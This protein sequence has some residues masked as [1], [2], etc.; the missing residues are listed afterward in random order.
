[1]SAKQDPEKK[2]RA[3]CGGTTK[4][5][6]ILLKQECMVRGITMSSLVGEILEGWAGDRVPTPTLD[7]LQYHLYRH[8]GVAKKRKEGKEYREGLLGKEKREQEVLKRHH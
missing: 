1:M 5:V 8:D 6:I 7:P 2:I 4:R 3:I